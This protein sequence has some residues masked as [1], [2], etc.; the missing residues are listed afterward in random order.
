MTSANRPARPN[1]AASC[2]AVYPRG[3]ASFTT[4]PCIKRTLTTSRRPMRE[5]TPSKN[6][7]S[8][9]SR[10]LESMPAARGS[11]TAERTQSVAA[12]RR[13]VIPKKFCNDSSHWPPR[14]R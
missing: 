13:G 4:A 8:L 10:M 5:A 14:P 3:L 9:P 1:S 11:F 2:N 6:N 12:S 7:S